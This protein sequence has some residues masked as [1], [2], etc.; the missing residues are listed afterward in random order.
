MRSSEAW[1]IGLLSGGSLLLAGLFALEA[2]PIVGVL[3]ILAAMA[4]LLCAAADLCQA[5]GV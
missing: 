4:L 5:R 2:F 3:S 1:S